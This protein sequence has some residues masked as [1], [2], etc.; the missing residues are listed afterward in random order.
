MDELTPELKT[1]LDAIIGVEP[2]PEQKAPE[3]PAQVEAAP[4]VV[5]QAKE[6]EPVKQEAETALPTDKMLALLI[7][8]KRQ[9]SDVAAKEAE[10]RKQAEELDRRRQEIEAQSKQAQL[11][12][13]Q[14]I[15]LFKR[16]PAR[17]AREMAKTEDLEKLARDLYFA[18]K[19]DKAPQ[20][21]EQVRRVR[22][23]ETETERLRREIDE[24]KSSLTQRERAAQTEQ[25]INQYK[26]QAKEK[27]AKFETTKAPWVTRA[28]AKNPER[29]AQQLVALADHVVR[30][31]GEVPDPADLVPI[32]ER[33]LEEQFGK[34]D[35]GTEARPAATITTSSLGGPPR[36]APEKELSDDDI[37]AAIAKGEHLKV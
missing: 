19:G 35:F 21:Y 30:Q 22:E 6:P 5:E 18:A 37:L 14:M 29:V 13:E 32:L 16:D 17:F 24:L 8:K 26:G 20:E 1:T 7:E 25:L 33:D 9:T 10:L 15:D 28:Y 31:G 4:P 34:F 12:A 23:N 3:P 11:S 36:R 2:A 27:L